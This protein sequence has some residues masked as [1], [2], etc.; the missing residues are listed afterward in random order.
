MWLCS[1]APNPAQPDRPRDLDT[2]MFV[3]RP[4]IAGN[5]NGSMVEGENHLLLDEATLDSL[6]FIWLCVGCVFLVSAISPT[7]NAP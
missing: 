5:C 2:N 4:D 7:S 1:S 3:G 6:W